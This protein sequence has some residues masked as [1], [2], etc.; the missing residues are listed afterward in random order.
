MRRMIGS[1]VIAAGLTLAPALVAAQHSMSMPAHELGV[2][3]TLF[4]SHQSLSGVSLN[5]FIFGTP[6]DLRLGF[7]SGQKLVIEPRIGIAFDS[8]GTGTSSSYQILPDVNALFN[9]G[10]GTYKQGMYLTVGAGLNLTHNVLV[11]GSASQFS[12]NGGIGTR[13]PWESGAMRLE[14]FVRN[15]FKNTSKGLPSA[16]DIGARVGLSLWH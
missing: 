7:V 8:K 14:A 6:V 15:T 16:L 4:Y 1:A 11:A 9:L 12:V 2:D 10:S 5:H 13:M 3:F